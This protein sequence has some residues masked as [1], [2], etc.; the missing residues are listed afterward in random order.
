MSSTPDLS[1]TI[2]DAWRTSNRIT[3]Q[4]VEHLPPSLLAAVVPGIPTRPI[5]AIAAHL[6][7]SRCWWIKMLG[8]EH[9][10]VVP[11]RVDHRTVTRRQLVA[12]LKRSGKGID[13]L[14]QLGIAAG[15]TLPRTKAYIWRNLPLDVGHVLAYFVAHE[16]HHRG[17][18]LMAARQLNQRLPREVVNALWWWLTPTRRR[19]PGS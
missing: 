16:G 18:I 5:R 4:F 2:R 8:A 14:L 15:G 1:G 3:I 10:M 7:N 9:G 11:L 19:L 6:H 17:Q 12:A 13:A